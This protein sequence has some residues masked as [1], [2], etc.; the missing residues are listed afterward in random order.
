MSQ[1]CLAD[2]NANI[3]QEMITETQEDREEDNGGGQKNRE[4]DVESGQENREEEGESGQENR[5]DG[6]V[7][8]LLR[9][10]LYDVLDLSFFV[11]TY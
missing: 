1:V 4:E 9:F 3:Y 8:C 5:E 10:S 11:Q 6:E 7:F 2:Y